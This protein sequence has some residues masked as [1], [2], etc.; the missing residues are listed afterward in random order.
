M[1][2]YEV[3]VVRPLNSDVWFLAK[4]MKYHNI[5][6]PELLENLKTFLDNSQDY[7]NQLKQIDSTRKA[8]YLYF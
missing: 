3:L 7:L 6:E 4:G 2:I 1:N 5:T 8:H